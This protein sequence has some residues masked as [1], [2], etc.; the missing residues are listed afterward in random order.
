MRNGPRQKTPVRGTIHSAT[1]G[2]SFLCIGILAGNAIAQRPAAAPEPKPA[3]KEKPK[4]V[5]QTGPAADAKPS[6][7]SGGDAKTGPGGAARSKL[8]PTPRRPERKTPVVLQG[9]KGRGKNSFTMNP[10]AKWAC[11]KDTV[12]LD[13]V[14]RGNHQLTFG[15]DIR[16]EGTADLKI[17][18][19][20]G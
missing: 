8:R 20:G 6:V 7:E 16:N 4:A 12:L 5:S 19:R 9:K 13:P 1:L 18:A 3:L 14:W 2:V 17:K 11:D 10:D 15:F